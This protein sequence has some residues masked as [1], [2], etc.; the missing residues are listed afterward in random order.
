MSPRLYPQAK[1]LGCQAYTTEV[2]AA[3][4]RDEPCPHCGRPN[5]TIVDVQ[6]MVQFIYLRSG[7]SSSP[8]DDA[9]IDAL[10]REH[11]TVSPGETWQHCPRCEEHHD[12]MNAPCTTV[13]IIAA[14]WADHPDY[15]PDWAVPTETAKVI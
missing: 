2:W 3:A 4:D 5:P 11:Q 15:R 6:A 14:R 9:M 8:A 13:R 12:A 10:L 7:E 1:C